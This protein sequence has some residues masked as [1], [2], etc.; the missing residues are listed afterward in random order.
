M[1]SVFCEQ[2]GSPIFDKDG[3]IIIAYDKVEFKQRLLNVF[4]TQKGSEPLFY[5]YG[6]DA[7][8]LGFGPAVQRDYHLTSLVVDA[9]NIS[10]IQDM[11]GISQINGSVTGSTGIISFT[12]IDNREN[13]YEETF[14]VSY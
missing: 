14:E 9:L 13:V 4:R 2:N 8:A 3:N 1:P 6:F 10:N 5:E 12:V 11:Y 7:I